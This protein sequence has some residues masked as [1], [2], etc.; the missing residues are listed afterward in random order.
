MNIFRELASPVLANYVNNEKCGNDPSTLDV[1]SEI[2]KIGLWA[3][4]HVKIGF[5]LT[6]VASFQQAWA[7]KWPYIYTP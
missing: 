7:C 5:D 1:V 2:S 4:L 6:T 3:V